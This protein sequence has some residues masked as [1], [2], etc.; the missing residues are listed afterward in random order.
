MPVKQDEAMPNN[1]KKN[2]DHLNNIDQTF[3]KI[4]QSLSPE[5]E[6]LIESQINANQQSQQKWSPDFDSGL[7][8]QR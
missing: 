3:Q 2:N 7:K 4:A 8:K 6:K 1:N 5:P